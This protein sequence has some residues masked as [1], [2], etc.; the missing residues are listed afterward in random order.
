M[1]WEQSLLE[2]SFRGV[3]FDVL[4][5]TDARERSTVEHAYPYLDGA[6]VED[7]GAGA[8]TVSLEAIFFGDDY[9]EQLQGFLAVLD[10]AGAGELIHP[11]FGSIER[12]QLKRY[13]IEHHADDVD[14][15]RVR[16]EFVE[17]IP[18][19]PFF[20]RG[21]AS[22]QAQAIG[23]PGELGR[24]A[25]SE[26]LGKVVDTLRSLNPLK[27]LDDLRQAMLGPLVSLASQVSGVVTS[28][29]DVLAV[30][31]AWAADLS[32][33]ADAF[34]DLSA[35][36]SSL[37]TGW[38]SIE[39][40]WT[41]FRDAFAESA[42]V[43]TGVTTWLPGSAPSEPQAIAAVAATG[44]VTGATHVALAASDLLQAEAVTPTLSPPEIEEVANA[45]RTALDVA[46]EDCRRT[47]ALET[48]RAIA[49]P[50]RTQAL[51]VQSA[52][53]A[54]IEARPPLLLRTVEVTGNLRLQAHHWYA[55]HARAPELARLN[56]TLRL[57]NAL[58]A[59]EAIHAFAR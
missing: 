20:S 3:V 19:Q 12:A 17:A 21:L 39:S 44:S 40:Q 48:A 35:S 52:A 1:A 8:R 9:E 13:S 27:P 36:G 23:A 51:A 55:D 45:A 30:P 43:A 6:D 56:P 11:V 22:L 18:G 28:G 57:P 58:Q 16:V 29:L 5:T 15:A 14:A 47:F 25:V 41:T 42:E 24:S 32:T 31:R 46:I 2:A 37:M 10:E 49:E 26:A 34:F 4:A 38:R 59:G 50:L 7:L 53:Q 54:I 33:I